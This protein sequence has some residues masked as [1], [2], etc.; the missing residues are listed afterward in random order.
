[1]D[2]SRIAEAASLLVA[3]RQQRSRIEGLPESCRPRTITE[4][5]A[6]QDAATAMLRT[7][8]SAYKANASTGAAALSS[9]ETSA[10][11]VNATTP[12]SEGIRAPIYASM[13][14]PSPA[15][16]P[17]KDVPQCGV[18]GEVAFRFRRDLPPRAEPYTQD[19]IAQAVDACPA[20]EVVTSRFADPD[21]ATFLEKLADCVSNGGFVYG[22][23]IENWH[24]LNFHDLKVSLLVNGTV[25]VKQSGGHPNGNLLGIVVAL[26]EMMRGCGGVKAGQFVT[27]GSYTGLRYLNPGDTCHVSFDGLG[28]AEI[29]FTT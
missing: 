18:E 5:H 11:P 15:R 12:P 20:I 14:R 6:I 19:E 1:M 26:V 10:A 24:N 3:A 4:A 22:S 28:S 25:V 16:I 2:Q 17:A 8:V 23:P 27:C 13:T 9:A 7:E 29:Q 21:T